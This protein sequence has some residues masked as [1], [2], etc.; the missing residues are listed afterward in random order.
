MLTKKDIDDFLTISGVW[1][2]LGH[3]ENGDLTTAITSR[4][5]L[6]KLIELAYEAGFKDGQLH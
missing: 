2:D 5:E 4:E 1:N 3:F 6:E